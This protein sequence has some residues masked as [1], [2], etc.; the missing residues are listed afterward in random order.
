[1]IFLLLNDFVP[2]GFS[3]L[4][5][6]THEIQFVTELA[7]F[8]VLLPGNMQISP[9]LASQIDFLLLCHWNNY[10]ISWPQQDLNLRPLDYESIASDQLSYGA[11]NNRQDFTAVSVPA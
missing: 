11:I 8:D 6:G 2:S 1:M 10:L 9:H 7:H 3:G 4:A 5:F